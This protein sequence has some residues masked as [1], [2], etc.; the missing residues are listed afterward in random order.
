MWKQDRWVDK[1]GRHGPN[2]KDLPVYSPNYS[3]DC[4]DYWR[5]ADGLARAHHKSVIPLVA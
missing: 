1:R 5:M 2:S 3:H 4:K